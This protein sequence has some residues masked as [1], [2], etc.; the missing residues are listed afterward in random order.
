MAKL[1]MDEFPAAAP[2][3]KAYLKLAGK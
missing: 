1:V 3:V 2:E